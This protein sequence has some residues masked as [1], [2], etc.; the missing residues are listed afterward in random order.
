MILADFCCPVHGVF[1][2]MAEGDA[3]ES[4]CPHVDRPAEQVGVHC[5]RLSPWSPSPVF[6]RVQLVTATTGRWDKAPTPQHLDTL[7]TLGAGQRF[8]EW[9]ADRRKMW[10]EHDWKRRKERA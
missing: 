2:A 8:G 6:G 10:R 3:D 7:T 9:K 5:G 4:P 1:E